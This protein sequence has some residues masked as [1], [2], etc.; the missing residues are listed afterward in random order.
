MVLISFDGNGKNFNTVIFHCVFLIFSFNVRNLP[1]EIFG[2]FD[3]QV[4]V[5]PYE[6][7]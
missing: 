4:T 2:L 3:V 1:D 6:F 7:L 5:R